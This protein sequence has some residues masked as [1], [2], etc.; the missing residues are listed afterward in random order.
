MRR[1]T[2]VVSV[3]AALSVAL[4]FSVGAAVA[5]PGNGNSLNP[6]QLANQACHAQKQ[7]LGNKAFKGLYGKHAMRTCKRQET[8]TVEDEAQNAAQECKAE[9]ADPN[10]A[11]EHGGATFDEFYGTNTPNENGVNGSNQNAFGKCVSG[12]VRAALAEEQEDLLNAAKECKAERS[13]PDFAAGH[14]GESFA[15]F[16][17]TNH[18]KKNALGKCVSQKAHEAGEEDEPTS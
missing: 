8:G 5:K 1:Q 17:G 3:A 14:G 6:H 7:E 4:V 15:D 11:T 13:D 2:L 18:N 9:Q 16:Y 12:K 10:F